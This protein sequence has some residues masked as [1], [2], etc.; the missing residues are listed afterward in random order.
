MQLNR[1]KNM[2]PIK[3]K[4]ENNQASGK[5]KCRATKKKITV[6][7]FSAHKSMPFACTEEKMIVT[8]MGKPQSMKRTGGRAGMNYRFNRQKK[9][10][11]EFVAA[12]SKVQAMHGISQSRSFGKANIEVRAHFIFPKKNGTIP[13]DVDNLSKFLLDC[14]QLPNKDGDAICDNDNQTLKL[15]VSKKYGIGV[16]QG[17]TIFE[18][19]VASEEDLLVDYTDCWDVNDD[20]DVGDGDQKI[21]AVEVIDLTE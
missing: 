17:M 7:H 8:V 11:E 21:A 12:V 15:T 10:Q 13:N 6:P 1:K 9:L 14:F 20:N 5:K 4:N 2:A 19:W 16:G 18:I 3:R